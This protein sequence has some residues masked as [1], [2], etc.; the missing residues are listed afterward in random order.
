MIIKRV[1]NVVWMLMLSENLL[2]GAVHLA[3]Y[4]INRRCT[5]LIIITGY[6]DILFH[7]VYLITACI[8]IR[9]TNKIRYLRY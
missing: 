9:S 5:R 3:F 8:Y 6:I 1:V 7:W 2:T 4:L